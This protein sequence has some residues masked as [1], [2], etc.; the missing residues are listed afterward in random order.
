VNH[1]FKV[2]ILNN[3]INPLFV[4]NLDRFQMKQFTTF[5]ALLSLI[6]TAFATDISAQQT[7]LIK[8]LN[9]GSASA[10]DVNQGTGILGG[11]DSVCIF[12]ASGKA[13]IRLFCSS[14]GTD[15]GTIALLPPIT[16]SQTITQTAV[17][18]NLFWFVIN[19]DDHSKL[20]STD[21][22]WAGTILRKD[23]NAARI[24]LLKAYRNGVVYSRNPDNFDPEELIRVS[25]NQNTASF[26]SLASCY[27]FGGLM[28]FAVSDTTIW[29][30]G[31][32]ATESDR[33]LFKSNGTPN[34]RID[35]AKIN[36]GNEFNQNIFMTPVANKLYFFWEKD[37]EPYK[38]WVSDGTAAGTT[39]L[40]DFVIPSF[41]D[42]IAL[43][44]VIGFNNQ[45]FF[46]AEKPNSGTGREIWVSDGTV[47]GTKMVQEL[48]AGADHGNPQ[49]MQIYKGKLYLTAR[50]EFFNNHI[51]QYNPVTKLFDRSFPAFAI[52]EYHGID[53]TIFR[54]SLAFGGETIAAGGEVFLSNDTEASLKIVSNESPTNDDYF[55]PLQ[56]TATKKKLFFLGQKLNSGRELWVYDP[57]KGIVS[58]SEPV[59]IEQFG[60][61][62]NP[63]QTVT[64][65]DIKQVMLNETSAQLSCFDATGRLY[66]AIE[67]QKGTEAYPLDL[68]KFVPGNYALYL[69]TA[70]GRV[71]VAQL[72]VVP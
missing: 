4:L 1:C 67:I 38:L 49:F 59:V 44:G 11:L 14:N 30:I 55:F 51:W 69:L 46:Q 18:G 47:A 33:Y 36:T 16:S 71:A 23:E 21:G 2:Q 45:F 32:T 12:Y 28:S 42:L 3:R 57:S 68:Q 27:W 61:A 25:M 50:N 48:A 35:I 58:A 17:S 53:M 9:P 62:P 10:F 64:R 6:F 52:N 19:E 60:I 66:Q 65:L 20:Y 26:T 72:V 70:S 54:D 24:N 22:T 34:G 41:N 31:S 13:G 40:S 8:D 15:Q 39:G 5:I 37:N 63:G 56:F 43:R 29:G 7:T